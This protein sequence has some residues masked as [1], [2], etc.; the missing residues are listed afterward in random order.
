VLTRHKSIIAYL[1]ANNL[2]SS[3]KALRDELNLGEEIFDAT[4]AKKYAGLIEKKWTSVVRLQKK[5]RR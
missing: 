1:T 2:T 4:T 3:A 5:V